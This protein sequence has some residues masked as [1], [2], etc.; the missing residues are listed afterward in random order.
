ME[1]FSE[2]MT[3]ACVKLTNTRKHRKKDFIGLIVPEDESIMVGEPYQE[4]AGA[5]S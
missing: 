4:V 2:L 3:L 5:E 1:A